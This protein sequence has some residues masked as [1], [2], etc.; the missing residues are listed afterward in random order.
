MIGSSFHFKVQKWGVY[1]LITLFFVDPWKMAFY[2]QNL[3][4]SAT[5]TPREAEV[6]HSAPNT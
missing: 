1:S 5:P 4:D 2:E 6:P 3:A